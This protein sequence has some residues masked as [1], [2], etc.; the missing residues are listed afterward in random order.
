MFEQGF[1]RSKTEV[2]L[3]TY[4]KRMTKTSNGQGVDRIEWLTSDKAVQ[5]LEGL[6]KW[7]YRCMADAIVARGGRVPANDKLTGPA[8]YEKLAV[9]YEENYCGN[10]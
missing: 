9:Y 7:H 4:V 3:N 2:A 5:V 10:V 6:K 8:G 1:V